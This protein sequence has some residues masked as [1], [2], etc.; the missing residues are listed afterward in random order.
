MEEEKQINKSESSKV[1]LSKKVIYV[2][3][4]VLLLAVSSSVYLFWQYQK[5]NQ[6]PNEVAKEEIEE[7]KAKVSRLLLLPEDEEPTLATVSDPEKL[8]DQPF[9]RNAKKGDKVLLYSKSKKA[10]LY[11]VSQ[12]KILEVSPF[13]ASGEISN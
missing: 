12:D 6:D 8:V 4:G 2:I 13:N 1:M 11:S 9:F 5:S 7:V 3:F 10:I